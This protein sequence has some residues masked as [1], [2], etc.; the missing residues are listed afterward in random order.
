MPMFLRDTSTRIRHGPVVVSRKNSKSFAGGSKDFLV[1]SISL[2]PTAVLSG[3]DGLR[4][5]GLGDSTASLLII[6]GFAW[7]VDL[8]GLFFDSLR[9]GGG[10]PSSE[11]VTRLTLAVD[12]SGRDA[13]S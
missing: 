6:L 8:I 3:Y 2:F 10:F 5:K 9:F 7:F 12:P 11:K 4:L 13:C 1:P